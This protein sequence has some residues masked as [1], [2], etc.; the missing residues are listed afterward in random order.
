[1]VPWFGI[2]SIACR[3]S[4]EAP[5]LFLLQLK[6][7]KWSE[8]TDNFVCCLRSENVITPTPAPAVSPSRTIVI[9]FCTRYSSYWTIS[10]RFRTRYSRYWTRRRHWRWNSSCRPGLFDLTLSSKILTQLLR[11][12]I[13]P[14]CQNKCGKRLHELNERN[15]W[16]G[17]FGQQSILI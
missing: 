4:I 3:R 9:R 11:P 2:L 13:I 1:M 17:L 14:C 8:G 12:T 5:L 7:I 16:P 10:V 6:S 15:L